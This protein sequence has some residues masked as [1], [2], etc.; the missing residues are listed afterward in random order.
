MLRIA[1]QLLLLSTVGLPD[2]RGMDSTLAGRICG[3]A[4]IGGTRHPTPGTTV[5]PDNFK[6][7]AFQQGGGRRQCGSGGGTPGPPGEKP[8]G[9]GVGEPDL[10][11]QPQGWDGPRWDLGQLQLRLAGGDQFA[12]AGLDAL[13]GTHLIFDPGATPATFKALACSLS[14]IPVS[15]RPADTQSYG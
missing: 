3:R 2:R 7:A 6:L 10:R 9:W 5:L 1:F 11:P 15:Y 14:L 13:A 8:R 12:K 4:E